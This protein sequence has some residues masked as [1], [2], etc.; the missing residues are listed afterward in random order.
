MVLGLCLSVAAVAQSSPG[1]P[2]IGSAATAEPAGRAADTSTARLRD[3]IATLED[4]AARD[5]LLAKLKAL[6]D[7]TAEQPKPGAFDD[8][9]TQLNVAV[10]SRVDTA[11][12]AA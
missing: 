7:P 5:A 3:L 1:S 11:G 8:L 6:S 12:E 2:G 10:E 4:P 9:V